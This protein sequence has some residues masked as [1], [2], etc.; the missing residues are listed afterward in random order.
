MRPGLTSL[1]SVPR[2]QVDPSRWTVVAYG[3]IRGP[4]SSCSPVPMVS[5][6]DS[7][8]AAEADLARLQSQGHWGYVE[9]PSPP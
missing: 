2:P 6:H 7:H 5:Y 8:A 3:M 1:Q 4:W 9:P